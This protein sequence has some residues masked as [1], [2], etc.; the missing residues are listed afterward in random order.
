MPPGRHVQVAAEAEKRRDT[1]LLEL[2]GP[3]GGT[4]AP[5]E[6]AQREAESLTVVTLQERQREQRIVERADVVNV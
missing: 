4:E 2:H 1:H 5:L 3:D 6:R